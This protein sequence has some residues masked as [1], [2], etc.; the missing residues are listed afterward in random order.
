MVGLSCP[1]LREIDIVDLIRVSISPENS[2]DNVL[3]IALQPQSPNVKHL[4]QL[5]HL[6]VI[7]VNLYEERGLP[8]A[9]REQTRKIWKREFIGLLKDSPS[10][11]RK[12]LR[13][14]VVQGRSCHLT[15]RLEYDAVE[16][17]EL[18][19]FPETSL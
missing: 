10:T 1:N 2:R 3:T 7:D 11:D 16:A 18:E 4:R 19:V 13:W 5:K 8:K 14:K 9:I 6:A 17:E 12:I 15:G